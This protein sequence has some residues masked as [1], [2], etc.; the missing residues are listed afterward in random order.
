V[1][2]NVGTAN[3]IDVAKSNDIN[4]FIKTPSLC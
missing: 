1:S 2:A 3:A 4:F